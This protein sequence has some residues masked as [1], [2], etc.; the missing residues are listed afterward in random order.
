MSSVPLQ[1]LARAEA[2]MK[3][4]AQQIHR[5]ERQVAELQGESATGMQTQ[6]NDAV[7]V[8]QLLSAKQAELDEVS[9]AF[10]ELEAEL[11]VRA[12]SLPQHDACC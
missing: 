6:A 1:L 12:E 4:Q 11:Q 3:R 5:L 10:A 8:Q 7:R 2:T 9:A